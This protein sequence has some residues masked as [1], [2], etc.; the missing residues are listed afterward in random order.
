MNHIFKSYK[1]YSSRLEKE[2]L[3]RQDAEERLRQALKK[4]EF[5]DQ[6]ANQQITEL[7][8][9]LQTSTNTILMLEERIGELSKSD[10]SVADILQQVRSSAEAELQKYQTQ[11]EEVYSRNVR[12][13]RC[14]FGYSVSLFIKQA[15]QYLY[16]L[17][18]CLLQ[19]RFGNVSCYKIFF[20]RLDTYK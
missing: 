20:T 15:Y 4:V 11:A 7:K 18:F 17:N 10:N 3:A 12:V 2:Q 14:L 5:N 1:I 16:L 6:V 9:R 13:S 8:Q 19:P